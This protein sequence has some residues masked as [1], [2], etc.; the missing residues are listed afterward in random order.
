[1]SYANA[2]LQDDGEI[3]LLAM[4]QDPIAFAF[5]SERLQSDNRLLNQAGIIVA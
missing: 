2:R 4:Q 1:L 5:I 3:A